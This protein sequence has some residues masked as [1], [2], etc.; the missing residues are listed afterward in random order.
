M[1]M[2]YDSVKVTVAPQPDVR[3]G[4][5]QSIC[6]GRSVDLSATGA[7]HYSWSPAAGLSDGY[8]ANPVATPSATTQYIVTGWDIPGC[9]RKDTVNVNVTPLPVF[10]IAPLQAANCEGDELTF[11]ASGADSYKWFTAANDDLSASNQLNVTATATETFHVALYSA[12]CD[13]RDTLSTRVTVS[14]LPVL[15]VAK[16]NDVDCLQPEARLLAT[17]AQ[18]YLWTPAVHI[19]DP[20]VPN[21]VVTPQADTWY[22]VTGSNGGVCLKEDSVLVLANYGPGKGGFY[23]PNAF[24]PNNDGLNDCFGLQHWPQTSQFELWLYNRWGEV[25]FHTTNSKACWNGIYKGKAQPSGTFVYQVKALSPC[26]DKPVYLKGL[27]NL[28]R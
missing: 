19:S 20:S 2:Q 18:S 13:V 10:T 28:V 14:P 25:V 22:K 4:A 11:T 21:P 24:T 9:T 3:T 5:D 1:E 27:F 12:A 17:G 23:I 7:A 16:S 8:V 6:A 26:S 15:T